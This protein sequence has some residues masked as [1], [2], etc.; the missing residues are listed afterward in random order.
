MVSVIITTCMRSPDMVKRAINSVISQ[1]YQDWELIVVD[2]SPA[3]YGERIQVKKTVESYGDNRIRYIAHEDNKGACVARNTGL[4]QA[5]GEYIAYLDD[6]DEWM[7][8]KL[9][10]QV[11]KMNK[12]ENKV[13]MVYCGAL[14]KRDTDI[15]TAVRKQKYY[16]GKVFDYLI[17]D[18]FI[19]STSF[20]LIKTEVLRKIDGFDPMMQ[21][22]QDADVW[23]KIAEKYEVDYIEQPLVCYHIHQGERISN[24]PDKKIN[25]YERLNEKYKEYLMSHPKAFSARYMKLAIVYARANMKKQA[26]RIWWKAFL[27]R[28]W[29]FVLNGKY[30]VNIIRC[31]K[32]FAK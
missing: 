17:L 12:A 27:R 32:Q 5:V 1:T 21:A 2:D 4:E 13:A 23:L 31:K 6:D 25:A 28:P 18:N 22:A 9:S 11:D 24:Y 30:L 26:L 15:E 10:L 29:D 20:P 8:D 7:P 14:V 3:N 19:G 16:K